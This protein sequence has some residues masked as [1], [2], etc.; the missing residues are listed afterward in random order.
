MTS[1]LQ[2]PRSAAGQSSRVAGAHQTPLRQLKGEGKALKT[3]RLLL[4]LVALGAVCPALGEP[5]GTEIAS[6]SKEI[7][8]HATGTFDVK[9]TPEAQTA[10]ANGLY[11]T[12]RLAIEKKFSGGLQGDAVG[13]MLSVGVPKAGEVAAYVAIDQF[14]G[15]VNGKRGS[16]ALT[17]RA[18]MTK[19]GKAVLEIQV[20]PDSGTGDL[21]GITGTLTVDASKGVHHYDFAYSLP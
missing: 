13:E 2:R 15:T 20:V 21:E 11:P 17:H 1:P 19:R 3:L 7:T 8:M 9:T 16:F 6:Q 4:C 14:T 5:S 10:A 18:T 12:A